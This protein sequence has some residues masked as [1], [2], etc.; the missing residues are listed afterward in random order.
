MTWLELLLGVIYL[1]GDDVQGL[2]YKISPGD[3]NSEVPRIQAKT[4]IFD[5]AYDKL[6]YPSQIALIAWTT[7]FIYVSGKD[8]DDDE[9]GLYVVPRKPELYT[10]K[11]ILPLAVCNL[12]TPACLMDYC[13]DDDTELFVIKP[14]IQEFIDEYSSF[15]IK[16]LS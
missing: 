16:N 11:N 10:S 8:L 13:I 1:F 4:T 2:V 6:K 12:Y 9:H 3:L 7:N 14:E 5:D 15:L